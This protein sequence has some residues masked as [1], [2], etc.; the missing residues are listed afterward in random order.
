MYTKD[1]GANVPLY[2]QQMCYWCGAASAEM[3]RNGYPNPAD[4]VYYTQ[5]FLWNTIQAH[6]STAPA[7]AGWA[8]DPHG[9]QGCLQSLSSAP[10]DWVEYASTSSS[11]VMFFMLFWMNRE[12]FPS[13]V[14]VNQGGHWVVVVGWETDV[15]PVAGS[16]P[17]LQQIHY[18]DPEPHNVGTDTTTT[19]A[20][21]YS[22]PWNGSV[23]Y[24]G[25]WLNQFVAIVEPPAPKGEV[26]V[27][28][29]TRVG[30]KLLSA[31]EAVQHARRWI[32]ER[33]LGDLRQH[34]LLKHPDAEAHAALL[35]RD[36]PRGN[37]AKVVPYYYIV[38][39]GLKNE[40]SECGHPLARVCV[41]VNGYSGAFEEVT[42]FGKPLRFLTR[43]EALSVVANA[44][45]VH[46]DEM[47]KAEA[48]LMFQSGEI[49]HVRT[50]PFWAVSYRD[51][52]YYVD[53]LGSLYSK[54]VLSIPGD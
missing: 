22:G 35:V 12:N 18:Y 28:T 42:T 46:S 17:T 34:A 21:W 24:S 19:G 31:E 5:Q 49:T 25:T 33:R 3:S 32:E 8:T 53:Q 14:L 51:R 15:E 10:V 43:E 36:E 4:R 44:L 13:P 16:S 45:R 41:L 20:Q 38:P 54:L 37:E 30:T 7:D 39:F 47:K 1:V 52:R 6:N 23:V 29:V 40:R 9:L 11:A 27:N 50:F 26:K 48:T 2:G